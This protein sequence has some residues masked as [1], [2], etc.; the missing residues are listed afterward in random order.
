[1]R[2]VIHDAC[3]YVPLFL[4]CKPCLQNPG[5]N[6]QHPFQQ[7]FQHFQRPVENIPSATTQLTYSNFQHYLFQQQT[8]LLIQASSLPIFPANF[9]CQFPLPCGAVVL[10]TVYVP[11]LC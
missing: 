11:G 9:P 6:F 7:H 2:P 1:M 8:P 4:T 10:Y 5:W 3:Q